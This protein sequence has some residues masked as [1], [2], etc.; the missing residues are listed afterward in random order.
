MITNL[1]LVGASMTLI[2]NFVICEEKVKL[3]DLLMNQNGALNSEV[4]KAKVDSEADTDEI[5][6]GQSNEK[7]LHE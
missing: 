4:D 6:A 5:T 3:I 1:Y 2:T 7:L